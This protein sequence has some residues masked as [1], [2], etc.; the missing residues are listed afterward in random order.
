MIWNRVLK[1]VFM[2]ALCAVEQRLP[3][4]IVLQIFACVIKNLE[5]LFSKKQAGRDHRPHS[6]RSFRMQN[7]ISNHLKNV[8]K[9]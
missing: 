4:S 1:A 8:T 3:L 9:Q 6:R 5:K 7:V 2:T